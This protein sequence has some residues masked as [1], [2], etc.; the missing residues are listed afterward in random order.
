MLIPRNFVCGAILLA[1]LAAAQESPTGLAVNQDIP[2]RKAPSVT[3]APSPLVKVTRGRSN[4][5]NL[6]F[7]VGSGFHVNSNHP[8]S[9]FLIPTSLKLSA[10]TDIA[11]T[12]VINTT[13]TALNPTIGSPMIPPVTAASRCMPDG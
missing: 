13:V 10:P 11:K 2:G 3:M 9:E 6:R 12:T 4:S 8:K 7:R 1:G 5:V